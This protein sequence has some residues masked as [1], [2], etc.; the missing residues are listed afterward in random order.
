MSFTF[1]IHE[2]ARKTAPVKRFVYSGPSPSPLVA[3]ELA[4]DN[5]YV[6]DQYVEQTL[7]GRLLQSD[8]PFD[9]AIQ[10]VQEQK[11]E[12]RYRTFAA[13]YACL[14]LLKP[15]LFKP[16]SSP[17][18]PSNRNNMPSPNEPA[19]HLNL[20][21]KNGTVTSDDISFVIMYG[22]PY[23]LP[24]RTKVI[25]AILSELS[26]QAKSHTLLQ[27][28][29]EET[30][31]W[32]WALDAFSML[33]SIPAVTEVI[34]E[35]EFFVPAGTARAMEVLS[36]LG[37]FFHLGSFPSSLPQLQQMAHNCAHPAI[38]REDTFPL[39]LL[40]HTPGFHLPE[41]VLLPNAENSSRCNTAM[42][43]LRPQHQ[44]VAI[45]NSAIP[46]TFQRRDVA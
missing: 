28:P 46:S 4:D 25:S 44:C 19:A 3:V 16:Q 38:A 27:A 22:C 18:P 33:I 39:A 12:L 23:S 11:A 14:L 45:T 29:G 30:P 1:S 34:H 42:D 35:L 9:R 7:V 26:S 21:I 17:L 5:E 6:H 20:L 8:D 10:Y 36:Y 15:N 24:L 31:V 43:G 41:A 32:S 37:C 13:R 40:A 2:A